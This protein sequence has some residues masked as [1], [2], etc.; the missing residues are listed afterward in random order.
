MDLF[1]QF[2]KFGKNHIYSVGILDK[3]SAEFVVVPYKE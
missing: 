1:E 3:F 2:P